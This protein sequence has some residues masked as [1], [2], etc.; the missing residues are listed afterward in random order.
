MMKY[1]NDGMMELGRMA[2]DMTLFQEN[3]FLWWG[4]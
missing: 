3:D 4:V 2:K 1:N